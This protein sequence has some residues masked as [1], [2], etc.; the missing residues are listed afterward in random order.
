MS[1]PLI[2]A[3][4]WALAATAT[5]LLPL[6]LQIWPG[7]PLLL[8]APVLMVWIGLEHGFWP[9]A[10]LLAAFVSLFRRPLWYL[11]RRAMG[12]SL[13]PPHEESVE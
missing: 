11:A 8:A 7:L 5:A 9:V 10:A 3:C 6:R 2:L 4:I 1:L 13:P 12:V